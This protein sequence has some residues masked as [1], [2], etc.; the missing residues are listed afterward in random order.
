MDARSIKALDKQIAKRMTA[1]AAE[2]DRLDDLLATVEQLKD[3]CADAWNA[4]QNA[5]DALSRLV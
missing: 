1:V 5:R 2:R 4:L 3:D